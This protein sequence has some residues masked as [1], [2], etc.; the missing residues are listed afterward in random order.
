MFGSRFDQCLVKFHRLIHFFCRNFQHFGNTT[1]RFPTIH[2]HFQHIDNRIERRTRRN[3]I[4]DRNNL[5]SPLFTQLGDCPII[6]SFIVIQL[7]HNKDNRLMKLFCI[8]ELVDC[9]DFHAVL[10][11]QYHQCRV[12]HVQSGNCTADKIV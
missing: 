11:I 1:F 5:T 10:G 9:A 7:V 6:I 8:P 2:L 3:R 4:L 12:C